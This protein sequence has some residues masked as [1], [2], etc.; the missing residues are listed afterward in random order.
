NSRWPGCQGIPVARVGSNA[1]DAGML[2]GGIPAPSLPRRFQGR[3]A[4]ACAAAICGAAACSSPPPPPPAARHL[5]LVTVDTLRA[6]RVGV[7]G[8]TSLTPRID[9]IA[10]DGAY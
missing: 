3:I 4:A 1:Y 2:D 6:D 9:R 7:Y 5:V 8:G 10:R